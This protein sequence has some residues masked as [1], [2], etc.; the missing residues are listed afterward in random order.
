MKRRLKLTPFAK[1]VIV[2]L[3]II[4]ARYV[5]FN[6]ENIELGEITIF[7]EIKEK[8][9]NIFNNEV[10]DKPIQNK[11]DKINKVDTII[12]EITESEDLIKIISS[13]KIVNKFKSSDS[14]N[15]SDTFLFNISTEKALV[16]KII[17]NKKG[18]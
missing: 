9:K 18:K 4:G 14:R 11:K 12:I 1:I 2:V 7:N 15:S 6:Q 3:I 16:G 10:E 8:T 17:Y 13:K 5:Y